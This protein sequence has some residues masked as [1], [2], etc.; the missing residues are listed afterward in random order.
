MNCNCCETVHEY[1]A[2]HIDPSAL[3]RASDD[4]TDIVAHADRAF[5]NEGGTGVTVAEMQAYLDDLE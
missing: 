2:Q 4:P 3:L 1:I 5:R